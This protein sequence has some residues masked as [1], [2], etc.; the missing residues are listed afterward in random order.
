MTPPQNH[1]LL[2]GVETYWDNELLPDVA[3]AE[4]DVSAVRKA[5]VR[6]GYREENITLLVGEDATKTAIEEQ[7]RSLVET[8]LKADDTLFF[9]FVGHGLAV[10]RANYLACWDTRY[11]D[12]RG[13]GIDLAALVREFRRS[14]GTHIQAYLDCTSGD[15]ANAPRMSEATLEKAFG[16]AEHWACFSASQFDQK[17][18]SSGRLKRGIWAYHLVQALAGAAPEILVDNRFLTA[19]NLQDYLDNK[20]SLSIRDTLKTRQI[21]TPWYAGSHDRDF[22]IADLSPVVKRKGAATPAKSNAAKEFVLRSEDRV[23]LRSLTSFKPGV[24]RIPKVLDR[25]SEDWANELAQADLEND[26]A[27]TH[28]SIRANMNYTRK[29]IEVFPPKGGFGSIRTPDFQYTIS[30]A[31]DGDPV[32]AVFTRE[33]SDIRHPDILTDDGFTAIFDATFKSI[34]LSFEERI[35][36]EDLIDKAEAQ[37]LPIDYPHDCSSCSFKVPD[38][39]LIHVTEDHLSLTY[40]SGTPLEQLTTALSQALRMLPKGDDAKSLPSPTQD[41]LG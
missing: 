40:P 17:S 38:R 36:V 14:S 33:V 8:R 21:Q 25:R 20:I 2:I 37:Q 7:V 26:L 27:E 11:Q 31:L 19:G 13:T 24:H 1:A 12:L 41:Q 9:F 23:A 28:K 34:R 32:E 16:G 35:K 6:L 10:K 4:A 18:H 39:G 29:Q 22:L 3:Y 5:L 30:I 15:F